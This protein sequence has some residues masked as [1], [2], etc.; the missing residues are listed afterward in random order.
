MYSC[1]A[2]QAAPHIIVYLIN[3]KYY[4]ACKVWQENK[5][6]TIQSIHSSSLLVPLKEILLLGAK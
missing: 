4:Y 2:F 3:V 1:M 5:G 6:L